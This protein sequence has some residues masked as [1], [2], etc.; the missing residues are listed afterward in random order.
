[1]GR[2]EDTRRGYARIQTSVRKDDKQ[3]NYYESRY[4][5]A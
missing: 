1:M 5:K 2:G 4:R 3:S